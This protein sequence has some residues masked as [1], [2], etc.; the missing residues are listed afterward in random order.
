MLAAL[1]PMLALADEFTLPGRAAGGFTLNLVD[2]TR[3]FGS[4]TGPRSLEIVWDCTTVTTGSTF[5]AQDRERLDWGDLSA[6]AAQR[7]H[8]FTVAYC[9]TAYTP[10]P[11][12]GTV[13]LT[14]AFYAGDNG[15][16][17][18][19]PPSAVAFVAELTELPG[20]TDP[21]LPADTAACWLLTVDL[22]QACAADPN[23]PCTLGLGSAADVDLDGRADFGYGFYFPAVGPD[24]SGNPGVGTI[25]VASPTA[26]TGAPGADLN[27]YDRYTPPGK[28]QLG[29]TGYVSTVTITNLG[30]YYLRLYGCN[31]RDA[32][33]D[34]VC[35]DTD[36][37]PATFNPT[38]ADSDL[39]GVGDICDACPT[40][41]CPSGALNCDASGC[42][43]AACPGG[44]GSND[45]SCAD[46]NNDG[47]VDLG[48]LTAI[49]SAYGN[50]GGNLPGDCAA[51]CG[52]VDLADL[53]YTLAR[54]GLA[55]CMI[56]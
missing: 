18:P 45:C 33:A 17:T 23:L 20:V 15:G 10:D 38:Q 49:L 41:S 26:P 9:S 22:A 34:G 6:S 31:A 54:Y 30:Q 24:R 16:N 36:N 3:N 51:P 13:A 50:A 29:N 53:V 21:N 4:T 43:L 32:D 40:V 14:V 44:T 56:P 46:S 28:W 1:L 48:D 27:R 2:G 5:G 12:L 42:P 11:N 37:C 35:D 7:A 52:T 19:M 25:R 39:D 47:V 55:G 8:A